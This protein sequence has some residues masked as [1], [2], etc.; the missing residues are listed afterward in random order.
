MKIKLD[1]LGNTALDWAV[2]KCLGWEVATPAAAWSC[3]CGKARPFYKNPR[4]AVR[5]LPYFSTDWTQA[6]PIIEREL[7][8]VVKC[9]SG[10]DEWWECHKGIEG[11]KE[12]SVQTG[13]T[14][15]VAAMRCYVASKLSDEIYV[16]EE[17]L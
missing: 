14:L 12:H 4:G 15:L 10:A 6:G 3:G 11:T 7:C 13:P 5:A 1:L 9:K 2:A 16:L 8:E 17:V